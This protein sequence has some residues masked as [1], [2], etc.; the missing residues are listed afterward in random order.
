[1]F[2]VARQ[3]IH[4]KNTVDENHATGLPS[5]QASEQKPIGTNA[6]GPL[7]HRKKTEKPLNIP[8]RHGFALK[9]PPHFPFS[10]PPQFN[11]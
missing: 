4:R 3:P 8:T 11:P 9:P 2:V 10:I 5:S 1:M 7:T 6:T